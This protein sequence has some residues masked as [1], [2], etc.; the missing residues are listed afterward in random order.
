[1]HHAASVEMGSKPTLGRLQHVAKPVSW[2]SAET[3]QS[4]LSTKL[5]GAALATRIAA[6]RGAREIR[7][8]KTKQIC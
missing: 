4:R 2:T 7:N 6:V 3:A 5:A 8:Q 1:M